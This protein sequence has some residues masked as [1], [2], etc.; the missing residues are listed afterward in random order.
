MV[1]ICPSILGYSIETINDKINDMIALGFKR[2]DVLEM[3]KISPLLLTYSIENIKNKID[4]IVSLG[5]A[6]EETI[7]MLKSLP[8]LFGYS[9]ENIKEKIDFYNS[10][11]LK[12]LPLKKTKNLMQSVSLSK[13]RYIFYRRECNITIDENNYNQ[14]FI[15]SK[16][17]ERKYKMSN[18]DLI[19]KYKGEIDERTI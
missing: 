7:S 6:L 12:N 19:E 10:I 8:A 15:G 18:L 11:G 4:D 5:Y 9:I 1:Q 3:I 2:E 14:L 16:E 13:A 17:F